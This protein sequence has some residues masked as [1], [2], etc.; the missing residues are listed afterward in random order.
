MKH[1]F[2]L[3]GLFSC[4]LCGAQDTL[5]VKDFGLV[6]NTFAN[7]TPVLNQV[8]EACRKQKPKVLAFEPG[9]YDFWP[10]G[11]TRKELYVTNTSS[12]QECADKTK[13]MG[14]YL[15]ELSDLTLE[16]NDC[17]W[18]FHGK[19]TTVAVDHCTGITLQHLHIDFERPGGSELTYMSQEGNSVIMKAHPDTR[20]VIQNGKIN[21]VGEGWRSNHI[22]CIGYNPENEHMQYSYD[23]STLSNCP[24]EEVAPQTLKFQVPEDFKP[25][26][27]MTLTLRDII[28][29]QVGILL[30]YS[31]S[32]AL[33]QVGV[34]YMHGLGIVS[35]YCKDV[36]MNQVS[37]A[38]KE[39]SGR[40]LASSADF[41]HFSGCRG[42]VTVKDCYFSGAQDDCINVHGTNLRAVKQTGQNV[43]TVRFMHPQSYG[44]EAFWKGDTVA[45]V[46]AA[47]MQR[48]STAQVEKAVRLN[49]Y[50][51]SLTLNREIPSDLEIG[52]DV[53]EN[54]TCTPEVEITG[55]Y[56]SHTSTRG[57]LCTTPRKAVIRDNT[58]YKTGMS[59][60]LVEADAEGWFESGPVCDLTIENNTFTDCAWNG[61]PHHAVI[62]INPSNKVIDLKKPVHEHIRI[63]NNSFMEYETG[64]YAKSVRDLIISGNTYDGG[65][66]GKILLEGC[67]RIRQ[68]PQ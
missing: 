67:S 11:A 30:H 47:T 40:I 65:N 7:S 57:V 16:G 48:F 26:M 39:G 38:P 45:L 29:D 3:I 54:L 51:I 12:E 4:L 10:E 49:N 41:M 28:R 59:A 42:K 15:N 27:G 36:T 19:M 18:M 22:H 1:I 43:I 62:A 13:I 64:I 56:F 63:L 25:M 34:H 60:I 58:F 50:E 20:Y 32:I 24:V 46:H 33:S 2:L 68:R 6:P 61:N 14:V 37:C 31:D 17:T 21:L 35:Q 44:Y 9:R 55:N 8:L 5:Y 53:I 52:H 66:S 23:W